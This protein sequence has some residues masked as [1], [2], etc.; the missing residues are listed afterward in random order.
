MIGCLPMAAELVHRPV[1]MIVAI[2]GGISGRV[3]KAS[4]NDPDRG[5]DGR[6]PARW[7]DS[8]NSHPSADGSRERLLPTGRRGAAEATATPLRLSGPD[9]S[10]APPDS[11]LPRCAAFSSRPLSSWGDREFADSPL[12]GG[13][14]EGSVPRKTPAFWP[15]SVS[16]S[17]ADFPVA[18]NQEEVP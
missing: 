3:A 8:A 18:G 5:P 2:G 11:G 1:D 14:F 12:E 9:L 13:G 4:T 10:A 6:G 17:R 7:R 15:V 16:R